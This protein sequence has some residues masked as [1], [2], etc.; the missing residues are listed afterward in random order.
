VDLSD[1]A[2]GFDVLNNPILFP[3]SI[4]FGF[5]SFLLFHG[6]VGSQITARWKCNN[7][8]DNIVISRHKDVMKPTSCGKIQFVMCRLLTNFKCSPN[9]CYS[10]TLNFGVLPLVEIDHAWRESVSPQRATISAWCPFWTIFAQ[11]LAL[12]NKN[13]RV[14]LSQ[15][16]CVIG[17]LGNLSSNF[18]LH[19]HN[20]N[21]KFLRVT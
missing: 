9:L 2:L 11:N 18:I 1:I 4:E 3:F 6:N 12:Y 16:V 7:S 5:Y 19:I 17:S 13:N 21:I 20:V 14:L 15:A 8:H 10:R